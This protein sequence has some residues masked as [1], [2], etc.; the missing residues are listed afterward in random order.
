MG[1][2][3]KCNEISSHHHHHVIASSVTSCFSSWRTCGQVDLALNTYI[4][5]YTIMYNILNGS[6]NKY[7]WNIYPDIDKTNDGIISAYLF[8][9]NKNKEKKNFFFSFIFF[10]HLLDSYFF[11]HRNHKDCSIRRL[12]YRYIGKSF[13]PRPVKLLNLM[14]PHIP[15]HI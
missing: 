10:L 3:T 12:M 6:R 11:S 13:L 2:K 9:S 7:N 8:L 4:F 1:R 5:V 14:V 15:K